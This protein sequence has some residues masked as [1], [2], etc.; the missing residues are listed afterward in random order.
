MK[1]F[2]DENIPAVTVKELRKHGHDVK[3]IRGTESEGMT[4]EDI[5]KMLLKDKRL[6]ITTDKGF[7]EKRREDHYGILIVRLKQPNRLNIHLK[8]M[9]AMGLFKKEDWKGLTVAMQD[10]FHSVWKAKKRGKDK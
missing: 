3:D 1:I 9:K 6:L 7:L 10:T 2:V 8:V 5:W 4:D